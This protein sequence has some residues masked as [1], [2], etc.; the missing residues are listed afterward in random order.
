[1]STLRRSERL[2]KLRSLLEY[3]SITKKKDAQLAGKIKHSSSTCPSKSSETKSRKSKY[4]SAKVVAAK[5]TKLRASKRQ[6]TNQKRSTY[7]KEKDKQVVQSP[8]NHKHLEYPHYAPPRSPYG[9]IQEEL[10][11]D[12]WKLLI[13]TIFLNRTTGK[14]AIPILWKFFDCYSTPEEATAA[15]WKDIASMIEPLG[16]H[17]KRAKMIIRF[18]GEYLSNDWVYP[19]ELHG[20]GKYGN[21]SYRI[22]CTEEWKEVRPN[23]HMLNKY[24]EWLCQLNDYHPE[25][26]EP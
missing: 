15:N 2:V 19:I 5:S 6:P 4:F 11:Q 10:W 17:I 25:D 3:E 8:H 9:L 22:F 13:A 18:S 16:L 1:M 24:Y 12:P 26:W 21:D 20:I 7:F 14:A 23:D